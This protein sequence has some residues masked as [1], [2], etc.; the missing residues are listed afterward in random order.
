MGK[1]SIATKYF[2]SMAAEERKEREAR[3]AH[4]TASIRKPRKH[5]QPKVVP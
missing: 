5:R 2:M 1:D 3:Q 4:K